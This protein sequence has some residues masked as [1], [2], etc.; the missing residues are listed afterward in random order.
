[1][2]AGYLKL[3]HGIIYSQID[4]SSFSLE[5]DGQTTTISYENGEWVMKWD[6]GRVAKGGQIA[7][8]ALLSGLY[9]K[10]AAMYILATT[11]GNMAETL[12]IVDGK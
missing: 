11:M 2:S 5:K 4:V 12:S 10:Y 6:N 8:A 9:G 1:M 7:V 3:Q